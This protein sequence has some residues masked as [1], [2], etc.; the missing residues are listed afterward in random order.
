MF[1]P[2]Y[3]LIITAFKPIG[4]MF[5]TPPNFYV[6][7]PTFQNF[8]D[9]FSLTSQTNIPM[10]RYLFNSILYTVVTVVSTIYIAACAGYVLS[11]KKFKGRLLQGDPTSP[12]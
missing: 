1:S 2:T 6:I 4:E 10:S 5:L 12:F 3:Y 7:K 11:K 9:L 8:I